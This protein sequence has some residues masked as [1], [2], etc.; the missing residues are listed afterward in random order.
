M[1]HAMIRSEVNT[2]HFSSEVNRQNLQTLKQYIRETAREEGPVHL[3]IQLDHSDEE[4]PFRQQT[5]RWLEA[6]AIHG[7]GFEAVVAAA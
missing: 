4:Q 1:L 5:R 3:S 6:R 2:L 7:G